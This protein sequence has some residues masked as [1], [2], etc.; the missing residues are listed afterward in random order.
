MIFC[1]SSCVFFFSVLL[2]HFLFSFILPQISI[3]SYSDQMVRMFILLV[4]CVALTLAETVN[5]DDATKKTFVDLHN[6]YRKATGQLGL[7]SL[8]S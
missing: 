8:F 5:L 3:L 4:S 1:V 7:I 6:K 2:I